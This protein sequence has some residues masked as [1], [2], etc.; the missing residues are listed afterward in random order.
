[1]LKHEV[2]AAHQ[3]FRR[4]VEACRF[5]VAGFDHPSHF[6]AGLNVYLVEQAPEWHVWPCAGRCGR[7][8]KCHS[9]APSKYHETL[10]G[11]W[12]QTVSHVMGCHPGVHVRAR[13]HGAEFAAAG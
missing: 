9:V 6:P 3:E 1:M 12:I 8:S 7:F 11:A 2:T 13:F 5:P 10:T 4:D